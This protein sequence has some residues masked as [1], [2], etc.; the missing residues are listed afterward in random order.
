MVHTLWNIAQFVGYGLLLNVFFGS[1]QTDNWLLRYGHF[2]VLRG[3]GIQKLSLLLVYMPSG[4]CKLCFYTVRKSK[5]RPGRM[6]MAVSNLTS[7][8][9]YLIPGGPGTHLSGLNKLFY[10]CRFFRFF[11]PTEVNP[12]LWR[13]VALE[14]VLP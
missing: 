1:L 13:F 12:L 8:R 3:V 6:E 11:R 5:M 7:P 10:K 14:P 9:V 2:K 4:L